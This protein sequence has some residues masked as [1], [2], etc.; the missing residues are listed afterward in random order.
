MTMATAEA[1][2][3]SRLAKNS[4]Q[5]VL[6]SIRVDEPPSRSGITNSPTMG[7]KQSRA[8]AA[9]PGRERGKVTRQK[10]QVGVQPRSVA[11]SSRAG[12]W[13]SSTA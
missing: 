12:S 11:A 9:R 13:R 3:Q 1:A 10:A 7:M 6:P 4:V 2:G 8:P 5:M